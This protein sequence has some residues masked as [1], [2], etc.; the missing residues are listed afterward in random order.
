MRAQCAAGRH[1]LIPRVAALAHCDACAFVAE[2]L[3]MSTGMPR[4]GGP[5]AVCRGGG[6]AGYGAL[7]GI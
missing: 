2:A 6:R 1:C 3:E 4:A 7:P 5:D